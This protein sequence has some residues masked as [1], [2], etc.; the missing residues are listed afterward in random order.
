MRSMT[1]LLACLALAGC[2][3]VP[4]QTVLPDGSRGYTIKRCRYLENCLE[5]AREVCAGD[6]E[7][8]SQSESHHNGFTI[9]VDCKK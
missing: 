8:K 5:K 1:L 6:Y 2:L 4:T 7:I 3:N 9:L